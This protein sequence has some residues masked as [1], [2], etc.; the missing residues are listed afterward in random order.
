MI[1]QNLGQPEIRKQAALTVAQQDVAGFDVPM[2]NARFMTC[3]QCQQHIPNAAE[4]LAQIQRAL[5]LGLHQ[6]TALDIGHLD[7]PLLLDLRQGMD[8]HDVGVVQSGDRTRFLQKALFKLR[9]RRYQSIKHLQRHQPRQYR[10]FRQIH[11]PHAAAAKKSANMIFAE[12]CACIHVVRQPMSKKTHNKCSITQTDPNDQ[13]G[14]T[15]PRCP[16][17]RCRTRKFCCTACCA[18]F[19]DSRR[20]LSSCRGNGQSRP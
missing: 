12:D 1:G 13:S 20:P 18:R 6:R 11:H 15:S 10:I 9:R 17:T 3:R 14:D 19:A 2:D 7:S 8:G 4:G 5:F 16:P